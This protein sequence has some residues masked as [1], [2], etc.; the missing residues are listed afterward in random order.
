MVLQRN[1]PIRLHGTVQGELGNNTV[2]LEALLVS[3]SRQYKSATT[4]HEGSKFTIVIK[5]VPA[6]LKAYTLKFRIADRTVATIRNVY[7]GDV[8]IMGGQSNMEL[9]QHD[10]Y[11]TIDS[12]NANVQGLFNATNLPTPVN[13]RYIRF[14]KLAHSTAGNELPLSTINGQTWVSAT[15]ANS[16]YLGYLPQL[17]AKQLR[18]H[19]PKVP[20]GII[21]TAWGGTD[22][23]RHLK[24]GDIYAN[25]IAPLAGYAVAGILWYQGEND[26]AE[27]AP[28]L[29]YETNFATLINQ[30]RET[31]DDADLPFLYVQLA[32][33]PGY[34]YTPLV[35]QAQANIL[36]SKAV[37]TTKN[38]SMT[39][40][41]DTDKGT[42]KV[43]HPLGKDILASR[44]ADQ[45]YALS[46]GK[47]VATGP[48]AKSATPVETDNST[49]IIDFHAHTAEGL[50]ALRP[51]YT[52]S[53]T[54]ANLLSTAMVPLQGF[55][56]AG[57]DGVFHSATAVI[58]GEKVIVHSDNVKTITQVRYL[59]S[60][61]PTGESL[62]YNANN[63]PASPFLLAVKGTSI[64]FR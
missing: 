62:L 42:A 50:Q 24:G 4:V 28:A 45:W 23:A 27:E 32:R 13:D 60:G 16:Q 40:S 38:L 3:G 10:Y 2:R 21:Q 36:F 59:W 8:F 64:L 20:I 57:I 33:Y 29:Q 35:R 17:F 49:V 51:N 30:Y 25:H 34:A 58:Q 43:I 1:K 44:M 11:G 54:S 46:A 26:A 14:I 31:F 12:F 15:T 55:E 47:T 19:S 37:D 18:S 48:Q 53:A 61:Y 7:V 5:K 56:V 41:L 63:L 6:Q 22:I 52:L 39:I 9:N